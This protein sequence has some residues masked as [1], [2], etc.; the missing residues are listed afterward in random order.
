MAVRLASNYFFSGELTAERMY[1]QR[2]CQQNR[3]HS[4][5]FKINDNNSNKEKEIATSPSFASIFKKKK[6]MMSDL[7]KVSL[8]LLTKKREREMKRPFPIPRQPPPFS[9][10]SP[11]LPQPSWPPPPPSHLW[12][13]VWGGG[14]KGRRGRE[15]DGVHQ[16]EGSELGRGGPVDLFATTPWPTQRPLCESMGVCLPPSSLPR[17]LACSLK[18]RC[19]TPMRS[20]RPIPTT[21][22]LF[23]IYIQPPVLIFL[24]M[25]RINTKKKW[26]RGGKMTVAS[27]TC[28]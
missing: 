18:L 8:S 9:H 20:P 23:F 6:K 24:K 27:N 5:L 12:W 25:Q 14:F 2:H 15:G 13:G 16:R 28:N 21:E 7:I 22:K 11:P 3:L 19:C 17:L 1:H 4:T 26:Q 10:R